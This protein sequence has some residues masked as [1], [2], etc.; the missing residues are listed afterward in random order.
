MK[1]VCNYCGKQLLGESRQGTS[2]LRTHFK[3]CKLQTIQVIRQAFLKIEKKGDEILLIGS[4]AF[5]QE[6]GRCALAKMIVAHE[7]PMAMVD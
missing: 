2:H 4:L 6:L 1:T 3:S 7:Y 5:N